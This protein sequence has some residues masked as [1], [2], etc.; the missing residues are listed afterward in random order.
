MDMKGATTAN[1][2]RCR[3]WRWVLLVHLFF[4]ALSVKA[5]FNT[6]RLLM[7][8]RSALYYEDYVLS[9]QYFNQAIATKPYLYEPWFFRGLA[10]YYLDDY[11]GAE[12]DVTEALK[13]NP[14][15][16]N[17]Y[18]LRGVSRIL[19]KKFAEAAED[20]TRALRYEPDNRGLWHN[21]V[22]CHIKQEHYDLA[23][24]QLD[25]LLQRW[26]KYA[27]AYNMQ[28]EVYMAKQDT[29]RAVEALEES[30][31]LDPYD[32]QTWAAR[33]IISLSREEWK[34]A[35]EQLDKSIHLLPKRTD[36]YINRALARYNRNNLRGAMA[37]YDMAIDLD[38]NSFLGHY[39]RGLL[40]AQVG[41]D[42]RAITDFDF[43]LKMEPDNTLARFNRAMLL[44][45][46]GDL[47][48]A[49][50]DYTK[51]IDQY[52][53]F[54]E[55][56]QAR[57]A[58]YRKLG[59][60][61]K[62]EQ[63]EF[64]VFKGQLD[65]RSGRHQKS[66]R[67]QQRKRSDDQDPEKYNQI[68]VADEQEMN[69]EYQS[70]YRGRVQNRRTEEEPQPMYT[71][72]LFRPESEVSMYVA[73]DWRVDSLQHLLSLPQLCLTTRQPSLSERGSRVVFGLLDSLSVAIDQSR[74]TP[75]ATQLL[76]KRAIG[77][78][79]IQNY[80]AAIEDL[81]TCLLV[82]STSV[83]AL[84]LRSACQDRVNEFQASEGVDIRMKTANVLV[85]LEHA[86]RMAPDNAY[87]VYN[88][89]NIFLQRKEYREAEADY[90]RAIGLDGRLAEAYFNRGLCRLH[91]QNVADATADFSKAGELGLYTAYSLMKKYSK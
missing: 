67:K 20:Y 76:L 55:G 25:T 19:Q 44:D 83:V 58:C 32:G 87:L 12:A 52:P 77:Y 57:A 84:W 13:R 75:Q 89:G 5:Q 68:V 49:I 88:R 43:V 10:K 38:P 90:T 51:V 81:T 48:A 36:T 33:S 40:R 35:E 45:Q 69:N 50:E 65:R 3:G 15:V 70:A 56:L 47:R 31:K 39:N 4:A 80:Q 74:N 91:L 54:W 62:A 6:D 27:T 37:D 42:N 66:S 63:D 79:T 21:R 41:D 22:L 46:T 9:I 24:A 26:P 28:A 34:R 60:K 2:Q 30:L 29:T 16:V 7:V 64:R 11:A 1:A 86:V 18:E 73:Y 17:C 8:G 59:M 23:L 72:S 61:A 85:D 53:N 82:D 14:Y 78:A 71:M